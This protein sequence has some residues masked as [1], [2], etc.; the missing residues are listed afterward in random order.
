V[1]AVV[2]VC[3]LV[4]AASANRGEY[5]RVGDCLAV[6]GWSCQVRVGLKERMN[7]QLTVFLCCIVCLQLEQAVMESMQADE[8]RTGHN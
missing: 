6:V 8:N 3:S 7:L 4:V 1:S 5:L 2:A